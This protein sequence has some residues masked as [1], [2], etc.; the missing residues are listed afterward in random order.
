M[1]YGKAEVG[2]RTV[3]DLL[4]AAA[5]ALEA[6]IEL[7]LDADVGV[8]ATVAAAAEGAAKKTIGLIEG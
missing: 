6:A 8:L 2:D 7:N 5:L 3:L 4:N 1:C